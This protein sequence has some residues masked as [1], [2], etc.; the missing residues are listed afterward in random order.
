MHP[1]SQNNNNNKCLHSGDERRNVSISLTK[2]IEWSNLGTSTSV[3][4]PGCSC[5]CGKNVSTQKGKRI[6]RATW[7]CTS[8]SQDDQQCTVSRDKVIRRSQTGTS[9]HSWEYSSPSSPR[10]SWALFQY[11]ESENHYFSFAYLHFQ[12]ILLAFTTDSVTPV[13]LSPTYSNLTNV[14]ITAKINAT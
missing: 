2:D 3:Q 8:A 1:K 6:H 11:P 12:I 14:H 5:I 7:K 10:C 13:A 4:W 9:Q